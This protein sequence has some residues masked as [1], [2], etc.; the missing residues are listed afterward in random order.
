MTLRYWKILACLL[1][2][3]T[4]FAAYEGVRNHQ[5]IN[6]DDDLCVTENP[7]VKEGLTLKS[8]TWALTTGHTGNWAP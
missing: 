5:F 7:I 2:A 6:I 4:T 1:L 8:L 3:L